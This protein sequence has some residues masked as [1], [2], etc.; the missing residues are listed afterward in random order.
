M[1]A[2]VWVSRAGSYPAWQ[3][4]GVLRESIAFYSR[5]KKLERWHQGI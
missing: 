1:V 5:R 4:A 2:E 3:F